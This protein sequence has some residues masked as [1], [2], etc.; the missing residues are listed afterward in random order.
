MGIPAQETINPYRNSVSLHRKQPTQLFLGNAFQWVDHSI[1]KPGMSFVQQGINA[2][3]DLG[4]KIVNATFVAPYACCKSD[5][6]CND[7][8]LG[9]HQVRSTCNNRG[10]VWCPSGHTRTGLSAGSCAS[11][12]LVEMVERVGGTLMDG[13]NFS[14]CTVKSVIPQYRC[15][16]MNLHMGMNDPVRYRRTARYAHKALGTARHP[17]YLDADL[18]VHLQGHREFGAPRQRDPRQQSPAKG[19]GLAEQNKQFEQ[20]RPDLAL[21]RLGRP[22]RYHVDRFHLPGRLGVRQGGPKRRRQQQDGDETGLGRR[23]YRSAAQF[24]VLARVPGGR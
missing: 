9:R 4:P 3:S 16:T 1:I 19:V 14:A 10:G 23:V 11:S 13:I 21:A 5:T 12:P 17:R 8:E 7:S 18:R 24:Q 22:T 6:D 15:G 2:I 20:P